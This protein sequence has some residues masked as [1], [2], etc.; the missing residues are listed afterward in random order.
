MKKPHKQLINQLYDQLCN[1]LYNI[2]SDTPSPPPPCGYQNNEMYEALEYFTSTM[3]KD[4]LRFE[5]QDVLRDQILENN[6]DSV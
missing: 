5:I 2:I 3:L 6:A 1:Q 4:Q